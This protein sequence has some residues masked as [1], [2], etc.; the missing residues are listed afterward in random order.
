MKYYFLNGAFYIDGFND[1]IPDDAIEI[2][3]EE[4][5]RLFNGQASGKI[6]ATGEAGS[7]I[8]QD[9]PPLTHDELVAQAE[10]RKQSL[11]DAVMQSISV[12]QLKLNAGRKLTDTE[13]VQ[14]NAVLDYI[15]AVQAID[16]STAPD[17]ITWP[18]PPAV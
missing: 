11:I 18:T 17:G 5:Q 13:T 16:T 10:H 9:P 1:N 7:P 4:Y 8:L 15:D 12:I 2:S 3:T 14:L 6:I